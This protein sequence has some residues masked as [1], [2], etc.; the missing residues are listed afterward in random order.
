MV[1]SVEWTEHGHV[2]WG[3]VKGWV[4]HVYLSAMVKSDIRLLSACH[5]LVHLHVFKDKDVGP[6]A[7]YTTGVKKIYLHI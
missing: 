5:S 2:A 1:D 7:G 4:S 6:R 3:I